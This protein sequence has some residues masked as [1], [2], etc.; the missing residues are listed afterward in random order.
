[1]IKGMNVGI[2]DGK[3]LLLTDNDTPIAAL[4]VEAGEELA[5]RIV[6][7]VTRL[8]GIQNPFEE[9]NHETT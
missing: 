9:N 6:E 2:Y 3:I 1:M 5:R 7:C 8:R 4:S